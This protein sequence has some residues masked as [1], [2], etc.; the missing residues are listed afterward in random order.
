MWKP[1]HEAHAAKMREKQA[2]L[3][4][5][6]RIAA[7]KN[8]PVPLTGKEYV[9]LRISDKARNVGLS[10]SRE[11]AKAKGDVHRNTVIVSNIPNSYTGTK[12]RDPKLRAHYPACPRCANSLSIHTIRAGVIKG[13]QRYRCQLCR[14]TFSGPTVVA[15]LPKQD[16]KMLCYRCGSLNTKRRSRSSNESRTGMIADCLSCNKSFVQGG[17]RDLQKYHLLLEKRI[18]EVKLPLDIAEEVL[19]QAVKDVLEGKGYCWTVELKISD[20]WKNCRGDY[21]QYGSDH[22]VFREQQGRKKY[23]N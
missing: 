3:A 21:R 1:E 16:Y 11:I 15:R 19:Q 22:P 14:S 7:V 6:L 17:M 10:K 2:K 20:A 18:A 23:D 13:I 8:S 5:A 9:S 12:L 4:E